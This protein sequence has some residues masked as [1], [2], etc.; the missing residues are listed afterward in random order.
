MKIFSAAQIREADRLTIE[1]EPIASIDLMERA[2]ASVLKELEFLYPVSSAFAIFCGPGNNGGDGLALARMLKNRGNVVQV[3]VSKFGSEGSRDFH[4]NLEHW[5][6]LENYTEISTSTD[7]PQLS[8]EPIIIDAL[9]G[10]GLSRPLEGLT[11]AL[12]QHLNRL[13]NF[14]IAIDLPSGLMAEFNAG[15]SLENILHANVT[16]TFQWP[17]LALMLADFGNAAG[18]FIVLNIG[19][20]PEYELNTVTSNHFLTD[21][22]M[23]PILKDRWKFSHKNS[24]GHAAIFGG[25]RGKM[26]AA[27]LSAKAALRC[28]AGLVTSVLPFGGYP[29]IQGAAPEVMCIPGELEDHL[30]SGDFVSGFSAVAIGPGLGRH[31]ET[32][33]LV[34]LAIQSSSQPMVLDADALNA[35]AENPTWLAF[36]PKMSILT[37]HPG[38][39]DRLAGKRL[40]AEERFV[41]ATSMA[42]RFGVIVVLKGAHTQ[43]ALPDGTSYFN[44]TGNAGM[45][46]A[47]T[48]D[49]LTGIIV[50]LLAQGYTPVESSLL[51]VYLHGLAGDLALEYQSVES[52]VAGD[53]VESL[54]DA[55]Q[56]LREFE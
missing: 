39:F 43:V 37:P 45:A 17:K 22:Q 26:G 40:N 34:K 54:G 35:L 32:E 50:G 21:D 41:E 14:K 2:A 24:Y 44:S 8:P 48:G 16:L 12:V 3:F 33:Q 7:F 18:E 46:T 13:P 29:V 9:F 25:S 38:E 56:R 6:A 53:I 27:V 15:N 10:T 19:L 23:R 55:F 42:L 36:L 4:T 28:G 1:R 47:G 31:P 52:L 30:Y 20:W 5:K 11:A 51:G 49:V